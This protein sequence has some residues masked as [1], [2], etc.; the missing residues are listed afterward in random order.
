VPTPSGF[1]PADVPAPDNVGRGFGIHVDD[2][3]GSTAFL[4]NLHGQDTGRGNIHDGAD[5]TGLDPSLRY[6]L[7]HLY[8][9][10]FAVFARAFLHTRILLHHG[11]RPNQARLPLPVIPLLR[12]PRRQH[13]SPPRWS[14]EILELDIRGNARDGS[15]PEGVGVVEEITDITPASDSGGKEYVKLHLKAVKSGTERT[16]FAC[17]TKLFEARP[18]HRTLLAPYEGWVTEVP[19]LILA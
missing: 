10:E 5:C 14:L 6:S 3:H 16:R 13:R 1:A 18:E 17:K 8:N 7:R 4:H 12:S 11:E 15:V 19:G 2:L 9:V